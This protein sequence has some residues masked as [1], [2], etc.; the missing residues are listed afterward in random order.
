MITFLIQMYSPQYIESIKP[1]VNLMLSILYL[2]ES[3]CDES[4]FVRSRRNSS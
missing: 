4:H 1:R 3:A 2:T